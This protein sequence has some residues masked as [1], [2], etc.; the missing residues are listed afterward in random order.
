MLQDTQKA[1]TQVTKNKTRQKGLSEDKIILV[2]G[3]QF[4]KEWVSDTCAKDRLDFRSQSL[5]NW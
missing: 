5:E 3:T 1:K 4:L 2:G